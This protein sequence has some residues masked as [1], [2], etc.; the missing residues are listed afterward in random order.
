M[1]SQSGEQ[2]DMLQMFIM[3][4]H[5]CNKMQLLDG[6]V[7]KSQSSDSEVRSSSPTRTAVE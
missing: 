7:E 6:L 2:S 5:S 3:P 1:P 4:L